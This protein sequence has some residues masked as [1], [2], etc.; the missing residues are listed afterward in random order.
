MAVS[1]SILSRRA[2]LRLLGGAALVPPVSWLYVAEVE[3]RWLRV[4]RVSVFLPRL[5]RA[6]HG[7]TI[8]QI[9]DLHVGPYIGAEEVRAAVEAVMRLNADVVVITGDFV[10]SLSHGEA[11]IIETE[12]TPLSAPLG[13]YGIMGNHDWWNDRKVVRRAVE[14]AGLAMLQNERVPLTRAGETLYLAGV[15]D[16]WQGKA[17]LSKTLN[18]LTADAPVVLLA[19]EPDY[20]DLV[21]HDPRV[22]LQLSDHS[23]GGQVRL[24]II[25]PLELP[26]YA[27]R[28][29]LGLQK[30][31]DLWVYT[32]RGI[33]VTGLPVRFNCRPEVTVLTLATS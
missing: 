2:F 13:V 14:G 8:A 11:K 17:D 12:L 16:Y 30:A 31:G 15:D 22:L 10:S 28:Y 1:K 27:H 5:P 21:A 19:H 6:F 9:S 25:G 32:N 33:G 18:G 20:A 23:H 4:E 26:R 3:L 24:P 7:L 29:P